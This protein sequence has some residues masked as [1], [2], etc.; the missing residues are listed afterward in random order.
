MGREAPHPGRMSI[1]LRDDDMKRGAKMVS[2]VFC[3]LA[4]LAGLFLEAN[5]TEI[6]VLSSW[7]ESHPARRIL[8]DTYLKNVEKASH[9]DLTFRLSGPETVSPFEQL[10]PVGT[11]VFQMLFTHSAYHIGNT[12]YLI[13]IDGFKGDSKT[14]REAGIYDLIDK[15]YKQLG[16]KLVFLTK[17]AENS[18]YQIILR[19]ALGPAGDLQGRKIRGTQTYSGVLSLL[20]AS[21]V[22]LPPNEVY[23]ALEKG[24]VDG[25]A[26][27][28]IGILDYKWNEVAKYL[29]RPRFGSSPYFLFV[30]LNAWNG[31]TDKQRATLI[32]EG[33]KIQDFWDPEWLSLTQ[34]EEDTLLAQGSKLT[35]LGVEQKAKLS[36]V[37]AQS[38]WDLAI[39]NNPKDIAD[40]HEF[41]GKHGLSD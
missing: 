31:L 5:A 26:W 28:A 2:R 25:A 27:P 34:K 19:N 1:R 4:L 41:A 36:A 9:G 32:D 23:S 11:G 7:D 35:E 38:L 33:K 29:M 20:R 14:L 22:V 17:S 13:P 18:G 10:Q 3:A 8:L 6:R 40:L 39:K 30:N 24:V 21:P 12:P 37:F 16:L 15:H